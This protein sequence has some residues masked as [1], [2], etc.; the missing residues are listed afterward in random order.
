VSRGDQ[1]ALA[2][3]WA[4][5]L[6]GC[7]REKARSPARRKPGG[8]SRPARLS[9]PATQGVSIRPA[10]RSSTAPASRPATAPTQPTTRPDRWDGLD[11][12]LQRIVD[13]EKQGEFTQ[14]W[15]LA[16]EMRAAF[17]GHP[18]IEGLS[19]LMGRLRTEKRQAAQLA[20]AVE[21]LGSDTVEASQI[22]A[23]TLTD[24]GGIGIIL[25]R[26]A[27]RTAPQKAAAKAAGLLVKLKDTAAAAEFYQRLKAQP[28]EPLRS[29]LLGGLQDMA[30][31]IPPAAIGELY[32]SVK[33]KPF[34]GH[35]E[36]F[37]VLAAAF[38]HGAKADA[39]A[40]GKLV[41]DPRAAEVL[42]AKAREALSSKEPAETRAASG[43]IALLG[44]LLKGL[45]G[46]YYSGTNFD[47]LVFERLDSRVLI[48][49]GKSPYPDGRREEISI[50]W[51]GQVRVPV[52]GKY[53]F[54]AASDDGV[55]LWVAGE[56]I[57]NHWTSRSIE[58]ST[59]SIDLTRGLHPIRMEFYQGT[60]E[61][62]AHLKWKGPGIEKQPLTD[63]HLL[64]PPWPKKP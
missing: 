2:L 6:Q 17:A 5:V 40:F 7:A 22:A 27:V 43:V 19:Q 35:V 56:Q 3:C 37:G 62:G 45:R 28:G 38:A 11:A 51:T 61:F 53:T 29:A 12:E 64:T 4:L 41:G 60:G 31:H 42:K 47:K 48:E 36:V 57:V 8:K 10:T 46:S 54:Y 52:A 20:H 14:A 24:A 18:R 30:E 49:S 58:E 55:R 39:S 50:R 1:L 26:K 21:L 16:L 33:D 32:G 13:L 15:K 34:A 59:G 25:L 63:E 9:R 23:S 44:L